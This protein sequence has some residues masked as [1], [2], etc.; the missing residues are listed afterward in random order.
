MMLRS[1]HLKSL[2]PL[3]E[4]SSA[5]ITAQPRTPEGWIRKTKACCLTLSIKPCSKK[6]RC[7]VPASLKTM[8]S[9]TTQ[10]KIPY[11]F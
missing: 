5:D 4:I 7:R 10:T 9:A 6:G 2:L 11:L 1:K 3:T 8:F